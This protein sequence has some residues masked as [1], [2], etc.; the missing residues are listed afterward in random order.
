M[1]DASQYLLDYNVNKIIIII[2]NN[3]IN[4]NYF[5]IEKYYSRRIETNEYIKILFYCTR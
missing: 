2:I 5:V 3:N 1:L 4:K